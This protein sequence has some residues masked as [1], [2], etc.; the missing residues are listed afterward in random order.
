MNNATQSSKKKLCPALLWSRAAKVAGL[1]VRLKSEQTLQRLLEDHGF[2]LAEAYQI[3]A[4]EA[5]GE[6]VRR[7]SLVADKEWTKTNTAELTPR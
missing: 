5:Q 4:E 3:G 1:K 6:I 2:T 7:L